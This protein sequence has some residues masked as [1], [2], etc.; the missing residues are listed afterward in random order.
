MKFELNSNSPVG[1]QDF[2][3]FMMTKD[4]LKKLIDSEKGWLNIDEYCIRGANFK[5]IG[6]FLTVTLH[7]GRKLSIFFQFNFQR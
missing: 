2:D 5:A 3:E 4:H 6:E 7:R 1:E